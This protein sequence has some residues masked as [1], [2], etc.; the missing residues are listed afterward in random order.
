MTRARDVADLIATAVES[1]DASI[2]KDKQL[3]MI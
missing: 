3:Y 2:T 1:A